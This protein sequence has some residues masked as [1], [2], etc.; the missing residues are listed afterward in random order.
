MFSCAA[1]VATATPAYAQLDALRR[2]RE[3]VQELREEVEEAREDAEDIAAAAASSAESAA[4]SAAVAAVSADAVPLDV[5]TTSRIGADGL[6]GAW[7]GAF[8]AGPGFIQ[9]T[10]ELETPNAAGIME[11]SL[12]LEPVPG[13]LTGGGTPLGVTPVMAVYD[14][15]ARTVSFTFGNE[16]RRINLRVTEMLGFVDTERAIVSGVFRELGSTASAFLSSVRFNW[17]PGRSST[18]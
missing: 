12:R 18:R 2:A 6:V 10:L 14:S 8:P 13:S 9:M 5:K 16:A 1:V 4:Q 11:G 7:S 15:A 3:R 17:N